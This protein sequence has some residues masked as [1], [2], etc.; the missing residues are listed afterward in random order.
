MDGGEGV[1]RNRYGRLHN[2]L[3]ATGR[4]LR[5]SPQHPSGSATHFDLFVV[6]RAEVRTDRPGLGTQE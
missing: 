3:N 6:G 5:R 1:T 4:L 2:S